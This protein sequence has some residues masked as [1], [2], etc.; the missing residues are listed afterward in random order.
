MLMQPKKREY[1]YHDTKFKN[2]VMNMTFKKPDI[3]DTIVHYTKLSLGCI[4]MIWEY[5]IWE[6]IATVITTFP[7][8]KK[9]FD[10]GW[11]GLYA[12]RVVSR[13][14]HSPYNWEEAGCDSFKKLV[15]FARICRL[16]KAK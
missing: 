10:T 9:W 15:V 3:I 13:F 16:K 7:F 1:D 8:F 11:K 14:F 5:S 2:D 6:A 12:S 4:E